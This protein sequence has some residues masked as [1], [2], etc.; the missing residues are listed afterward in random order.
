MEIEEEE[1]FMLPEYS[2]VDI[3]LVRLGIVLARLEYWD[4]VWDW[5]VSSV[6]I[7]LLVLVL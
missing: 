4:W 2:E 3:V 7:V 1:L 5:V 6:C